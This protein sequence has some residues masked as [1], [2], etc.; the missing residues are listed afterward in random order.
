MIS[1]VMTSF[2]G[3]TYLKS[4]I[5]SIL[6][7]LSESDE[8]IVS[9]N[10]STDGSAAYLETLAEADARVRFFSFTE[11]QGVVP[12]MNHALMQVRGSI[13]FLADQ[14]DIWLD[15]R[16]EYCRSLF[17]S[18]PALMLLQT[19]AEIIDEWGKRSGK[20]FFEFRKSGPGFWKNFR[21]NTFQGCNM[22]FRTEILRVA[23]PIPGRIS[24]HD[25][26]IGLLAGR[27]GKVSFDPVV[28]SL[29]RRH[30]GNQSAMTPSTIF[31]IIGWRIYLGFALLCRQKAINKTRRNN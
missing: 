11:K 24:M 14:D 20:T 4:Q 30:G 10:G 5:E 2:N 16:V 15:G 18:D 17:D 26:W 6:H 13:V 22:I 19:N 25:V 12:N 31:R 29:Y 3:G 21:K 23:L 28:L 8:L 9:D 1:V 7:Q 27:L